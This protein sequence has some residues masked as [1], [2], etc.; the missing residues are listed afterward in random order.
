MVEI[1]IKEFT[2]DNLNYDLSKHEIEEDILYIAPIEF[3]KDK[4]IYMADAL[5][6]FENQNEIGGITARI[7][8][9]QDSYTRL[10]YDSISHYLGLF[11]GFGLSILGHLIHN[12][13]TKRRKDINE[14][15]IGLSFRYID[16]KNGKQ[17]EYSGDYSGL[18]LISAQIF[19]KNPS[20][21]SSFLEIIE[22]FDTRFSDSNNFCKREL[23]EKIFEIVPL[24]VQNFK[25]FCNIL[26]LLVNTMHLDAD[27]YNFLNKSAD[28]F[29]EEHKEDQRIYFETNWF[30]P[31]IHEI[32]VRKFGEE[33]KQEVDEVRGSTDFLAYNIPI[34]CKVI[35]DRM[36][37]SENLS[38]LEILEKH[39]SQ[40]FQ[41][42]MHCR[43]GFLIAYDYRKEKLIDD[44]K[45]SAIVERI[46]FRIQGQKLIVLLVFLGNLEKPSK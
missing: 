30:Q 9:H 13:I 37:Y 8:V 19:G 3:R 25:H 32:L 36:K 20:I 42:T 4:P 5:N 12:L 24:E 46:Q 35:T 34:E 1:S 44:L 18:K 26:Q 28:D 10:T 29:W 21:E 45:K 11:L 41:E 2:N 40:S 23:K 17:I 6:F 33:V 38:S 22:N 14:K 7:L 27:D 16:L 39:E 31:K 15:P 43:S